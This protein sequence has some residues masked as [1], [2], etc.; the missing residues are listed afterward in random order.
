MADVPDCK[1]VGCE[2]VTVK[3]GTNV[4]HSV[5]T[6]FGFRKHRVGR[7][8]NGCHHDEY[9]AGDKFEWTA[10]GRTWVFVFDGEHWHDADGSIADHEEIPFGIIDC[11]ILTRISPDTTCISLNAA[12]RKL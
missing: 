12:Y 4:L 3:Q 2:S 9:R 1:I 8:L 6:T 5:E 11:A 10:Q 7:A